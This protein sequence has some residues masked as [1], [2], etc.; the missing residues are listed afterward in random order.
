[1]IA[2]RKPRAEALFPSGLFADL[3][4]GAPTSPAS[5]DKNDLEEKENF[6][7]LNTT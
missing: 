4:V 6:L 2:I 1:M 7:L 5:Q 3:K